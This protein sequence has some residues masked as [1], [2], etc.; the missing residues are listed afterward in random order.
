MNPED[1]PDE[2][3]VILMNE[4]DHLKGLYRSLKDP[5]MR[6][7]AQRQKLAWH[8]IHDLTVHSL[9]E[10]EV[11]YPAARQHLGD[12]MPDHALDE[13][14]SLKLLSGDL[15]RLD[16]G[17]DGQRFDDTLTQLMNALMEHIHDEEH[18]L[19]PALRKAVSVE[20]LRRLGRRFTAAKQHVPTR[21][22]T[23]PPN[24]P[25]RGNW[26]VNMMAA[27]FDYI[28]DRMRFGGPPSV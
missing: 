9:A 20:E 2:I 13:H 8:L 28:R 27:P 3:H 17:K 11:L 25:S 7:P 14:Q 5:A 18:N 6:N 26:L 24:K 22:R 16:P 15:E 1:D 12:H 4:H 23:W 21:P 19:L 10:E